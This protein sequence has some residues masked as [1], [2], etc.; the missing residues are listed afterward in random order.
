MKARDIRDFLIEKGVTTKASGGAIHQALSAAGLVDGRSDISEKPLIAAWEI[1]SLF[2]C[3]SSNFHAA[4]MWAKDRRSE[5]AWF[6]EEK[7]FPVFAL[8][9]YLTFPKM[10]LKNKV[11]YFAF[12]GDGRLF[13]FRHGA[14]D[15]LP[16]KLSAWDKEDPD[17]TIDAKEAPPAKTAL[18]SAEVIKEL[19]EY[20][21]ISAPAAVKKV[22]AK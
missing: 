8:A 15:I 13:I 16:K 1:F 14:V 6:N 4:L 22:Y 7:D 2:A 11:K 21:N 9:Y 10:I 12:S 19:A 17:K 5:W 3:P 18:V 20:I